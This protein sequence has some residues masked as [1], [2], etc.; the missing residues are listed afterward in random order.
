LLASG[1]EVCVAGVT[2]RPATVTEV[3]QRVGLVF[4]DPDDQLFLPSLLEDIAFGPLNA[5]V[6]ADDARARARCIL[7]DFGLEDKANRAAH[8]L[9]GGE[10]RLVSLAT[11]LVSDPALLALDEPT[12]NLDAPGRRR[13]VDRLRDRAEAMII[14]TH[15]LEVAGALCSRAVVLRRGRVVADTAMATLLDDVEVLRRHGLVE[16]LEHGSGFLT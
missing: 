4:Q 9:S 14:A 15:D 7:L 1:G 16:P 3:R 8:H 12:G 5:G 10:K 11:V 2:V 13:L 6:P